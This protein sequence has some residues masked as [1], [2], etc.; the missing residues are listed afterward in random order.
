M[1][2]TID[3]LLWSGRGEDSRLSEGHYDHDK[4]G[5]QHYITRPFDKV[6][7]VEYIRNMQLVL[8]KPFLM[9]IDN[10][11]RWGYRWSSAYLNQC[12]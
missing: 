2:I 9:K 5:N 11:E 1:T 3:I 7:A 8:G 6:E 4:S 10:G 12:K